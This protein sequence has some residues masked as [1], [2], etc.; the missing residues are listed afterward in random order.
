[1]SE[2]CDICGERAC[3]HQDVVYADTESVTPRLRRPRSS[4][5]IWAL[6]LKSDGFI[7]AADEAQIVARPQ[8]DFHPEGFII[9]AV[10]AESFIVNHIIMGTMMTMQVSPDSIPGDVFKVRIEDL[11]RF[12][13][14]LSEHS[15]RLVCVEVG[16]PFTLIHGRQWNFPRMRAG[17]SVRIS[18]TNISSKGLVFR[19]AFLG[20]VP[21]TLEY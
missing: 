17:T 7:P 1:M 5:K 11:D 2:R 15:P 9:P 8:L 3:E 19:G 18:V 10:I 14:L 13:V 21:R 16:Q 12:D 4:Q 20:I 6:G